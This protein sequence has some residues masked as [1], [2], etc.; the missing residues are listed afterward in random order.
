MADTG[1]SVQWA[2]SALKD[3][4][5]VRFSE[6]PKGDYFIIHEGCLTHMQFEDDTEEGPLWFA[7]D[8]ANFVGFSWP[9][10]LLDKWT[11]ADDLNPENTE[12]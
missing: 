3:G 1:K 4:H 8:D 9:E 12:G 6:W 5:K 7:N 2:I 11:L 10:C